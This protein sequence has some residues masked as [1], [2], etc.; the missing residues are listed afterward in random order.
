MKRLGE[1]DGVRL[2]R[3]KTRVT[4]ALGDLN[5]IA[6]V[7]LRR[8]HGNRFLEHMLA[9]KKDN[10]DPWRFLRWTVNA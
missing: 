1:K 4:E 6:M 10:G 3:T 8:D 5:E 9:R 7:D 2:D